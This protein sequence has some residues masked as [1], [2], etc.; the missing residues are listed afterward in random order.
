MVADLEGLFI[1]LSFG[2]S[3]ASL[4]V[5]YVTRASHMSVRCS[6]AAA[7]VLKHP[8]Q[9]R[10]ERM[11]ATMAVKAVVSA[12]GNRF[13]PQILSSTIGICRQRCKRKF[14]MVTAM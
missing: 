12:T 8:K 2:R 11:M 4:D 5:V 13:S 14:S 1:V 3:Q 6:G 10:T 7:K 9:R